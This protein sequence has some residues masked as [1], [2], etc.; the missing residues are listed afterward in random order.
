MAYQLNINKKKYPLT[1]KLKNK[2]KKITQLVEENTN[3]DKRKN[4]FLNLILVNEKES[5]QLNKQYRQKDYP[6]DVLAFPF[7]Q[8]YQEKLSDC[9]DLGD[10]FLCYPLVQ[11]QVQEFSSSLEEEI[12]L[13]FTHG[14]L[15]LLGYDHKKENER[16]AMFALQERILNKIN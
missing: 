14:M 13:I 15:H 12:C 11:K 8:L 5:Q 10:I 7:A 4:W 6:T 1:I 2:L 16:K 3:L 9:E